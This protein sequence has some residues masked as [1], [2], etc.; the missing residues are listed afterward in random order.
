MTT[1]G[2]FQLDQLD[3]RI[4]AVWTRTQTRSLL[5][6][7]LAFVRWAVP[8]FIVAM[9]IDW[10]TYMPVGG[11]VVM[12]V[13]L[14]AVSGYRA[15]RCGWRHLRPFNAVRTALQ[16]ESHRG[17]LS[18]L[19]VSAL[20]LRAQP[21]NTTDSLSLRQH[22]CKLA[23]VAAAGLR[24]D[25]AVPYR[26][27]QNPGLYAALFLAVIGVFGII[28]STFLL[29][30]VARIFTPWVA[31]EYPTNTQI[32]LDQ[33]ELIIKEGDSAQ[34]TA[35]LQGVVPKQATIYV[36]TGEG[37]ARAIDL[38]VIQSSS[39]YT[40]ASASR[41]FTYRIKAGDDRTAWHKVRVVPAP[42]IDEVK[43]SLNYPAYLA[44]DKESIEALT[45]TVPEGT[46]IQWQLQLDRPIKA[47][48]FVRDGQPPVDLDISGDGKGLA[49]SDA[50]TASQ[51]YRFTWVDRQHGFAFESPRYFMQ[52]AADQT[53]RVEL[54]S[55][56]K[57]LAAM[58]G[59]PLPL[60]VRV[61][62]DH[63]IGK[64]TIAYRVNQREE[65][66]VELPADSL[67]GTGEQ[68]IDWDYRQT[69]GDLKIGDTVSFTVQVSDLYPA[70]QGP[71]TVRSETR[72]ITFLSREKYLEQINKQKDRLLSRVQTIYRQQRSAHEVVLELTPDTEG[73][74]Q[75]CQL[76]AI[77]QEMVRDQLKDVA[78]Q[79]QELLDDLAANNIS[80]AAEA[81]DLQAIRSALM[82]IAESHIAR[83]AVLLRDLSGS[84][85]SGDA[86]S[87]NP[88]KA[89]AAVNAAA[90]ELGKLV[91]LRGIDSAQEVYARE[92]RM[93][94]RDQA[95]LRWRTVTSTSSATQQ[96]IAERQ[97][98]IAQWTEELTT[99]LQQSIRYDKR[100]LAVLRLI[101]SV[102]DLR[103]AKTSER[104]RQAS[105]LIR[106]DQTQQAAAMQAD[107]VRTLLNAEFSVRLSGAFRTLLQTRDL[108]DSLARFQQQLQEQTAGLTASA[109]SAQR[110]SLETVQ[111]AL[112]KQL[113][114]MLLPTVP[115]P[116]ALLFD[117]TP[118]QAPP[119]EALL[120]KADDA[121]AKSLRDLKSGEQQGAIAQQAL[122]EQHL[123]ELL[124]LVERWSVEMGLQTQGLSTLVAATSDRM[125]RLEDYE[126]RIIS[127]LEKTDIAASD[128]APVQNLAGPQ[129]DLAGELSDYI[130]SL[131]KQNESEPDQGLPPLLS[132]L[133]RV[134]QALSAASQSL[135]QNKPDAAIQAQEQA[136]DAI[137]QA[138]AIVVAQNERLGLLQDLLMFQRSVGFA[139]GYMA[140]IVAQQRDLLAATEASEPEAMARMLPQFGHMRD[141]LEGVAP[142]L[143]LVAGRLDVGTPLVF[144]KTDFSDAMASLESGDK[145]DAVDA[146]DVAAESIGKVQGLV[147]DIQMQTGYIAEIVAYLHHAVSDTS[148]LAYHQ[149]ELRGE[150]TAVEHNDLARFVNKQQAILQQARQQDTEL[151]AAAGNPKLVPPADPLLGITSP[152]QPEPVLNQVAK[153][154]ALVIEALKDNDP[155]AAAEQ[156]EHVEQIY[157]ENAEA[158]LAVITMLH[159]LPDIEI[160]NVSDPALVRLVDVLAIASDHKQLFR[161]SQVADPQAYDKL[162]DRQSAIAQRLM[163]AAKAV[164]PHPLLDQAVKLAG[165][166]LTAFGASNKEAIGLTQ[167][168][169]DEALRH[170]V[171]E[172]ALILQ[173][174]K[175]P[176]SASDAPAADGPGSDSEAD[177]TA[178]FIA[179]FVSGEAPTDGRSEWKVLADRN[180]A[181]L[182]QNFARELPLEF[183]GLLKNYYERV[184]R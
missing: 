55:P 74:L 138:D 153:E 116:R 117:E 22:T 114:T 87:A 156:M 168:G 63:G 130:K 148:M 20:Q 1:A 61:Q 28:N 113:I 71:H 18:S 119:I 49:F 32:V 99:D 52:V 126:V 86:L 141:C 146:Q 134:E 13:V 24:P 98:E 93:L 112:R 105:G 73:Y 167:R 94:A 14:L 179:D 163:A 103:D 173:T 58:I 128:K 109:F 171:I 9:L 121:M 89:V 33:Q 5:A 96:Q 41:D 169:V 158:M 97:S 60:A 34:I 78:G 91:M 157:A 62:D 183:R 38:E 70:P 172:Q 127:L 54:T 15:W 76:E 69:L 92:A 44:R 131:R 56:T 144:A 104:M 16:L 79:M 137:A 120:S 85:A 142:L 84:V 161:Q 175:P 39:T 106:Q 150:L 4:K 145:F 133:K 30:G 184:A 7:L 164:E 11:R 51:G 2:T 27:L 8:L 108:I 162:K 82:Q 72:R 43:V 159:G 47:A 122:A 165:E 77:R 107:L 90:R 6:G 101:R 154:M 42:R 111:R 26:P 40:I 123:A 95:A 174:F 147:H 143:D 80:D 100:P 177:V 166:A 181:A 88:D 3:A 139:N 149:N 50:V 17:D 48:Q 57:N 31:I 21:A 124:R 23:E 136:A 25:Q 176:P 132:Q 152:S 45:V 75:A 68:A 180:R 53:P 160:T 178:G 19:L 29:A 129:G 10:L 12:L 151:L 37:R 155:Q 81:G 115:A 118:P 140:D 46:G 125:S 67:N 170:F 35:K 102:K 83:G 64:S 135:E 36:R 66:V 110:K 182:N 65:A 59:R